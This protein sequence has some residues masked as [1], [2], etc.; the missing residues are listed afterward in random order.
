MNSTLHSHLSG[1]GGFLRSPLFL[2]MSPRV[3][4]PVFVLTALLLLLLGVSVWWALAVAVLLS[5]AAIAG[6]FLYWRLPKVARAVDTVVQTWRRATAA[7]DRA[8]IAATARRTPSY[9]GQ[10]HWLGLLPVDLRGVDLHEA[11]LSSA[12]LA[13]MDLRQARLEG[14]T[15]YDADLHDADLRGADLRGADL[16]GTNLR[17]ADLGWLTVETTAGFRSRDPL[18]PEE[19]PNL[20]EAGGHGAQSGST[21][22]GSG[23]RTVEHTVCASLEQASLECAN[24]QG[25]NL[26]GAGLQGARLAGADLEGANLRG[27]R[28][29]GADL[30]G[31]NLAR[32]NLQGASL[33]GANLAGANLNRANLRGLRL[34]R[35]TQ[36]DSKWLL[37]WYIL[38]HGGEEREMHGEDLSRAYLRQ[39]D[40]HSSDL[41]EANMSGCDLREADLSHAL[42][43]GA[44]LSGADLRQASLASA[45]L[46]S[47][48]LA[49]ADLRQADLQGSHLDLADL[50]GAD[51]EGADLRGSRLYEAIVSDE[52]L[53]RALSLDYALLPDGTMQE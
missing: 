36:L 28:L 39:A 18:S 1:A 22:G 48:T 15:L 12:Q 16:T 9:L 37:V 3:V 27:A 11:R 10:R 14:A 25:A 47:A 7:A 6:L 13:G 40:L 30:A 45:E 49:G 42:L 33:L 24:L 46:S 17:G 38:T 2:Q 4:A 51:L 5:C 29:A 53:A 19:A 26:Q 8:V 31:A 32:A 50:Q 35:E 44:N 23:A 52:Q 43:S 21:R 34:D 20:G 41:G